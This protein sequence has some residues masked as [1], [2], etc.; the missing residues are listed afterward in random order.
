[1]IN[2]K[3]FFLAI[4][5]SLNFI[6]MNSNSF[7]ELEFRKIIFSIL[8]LAIIEFF[9]FAALVLM[10]YVSV[11]IN[12]FLLYLFTGV[13]FSRLLAIP[14]AIGGFLLVKRQ[15]DY[16]RKEELKTIQHQQ[17]SKQV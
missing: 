7:F 10:F 16:Q 13:Y 8:N 3:Y 9:E 11:N 4:F 5:L 17:R 2:K 14:A 15:I 6:L 1:M 12:A